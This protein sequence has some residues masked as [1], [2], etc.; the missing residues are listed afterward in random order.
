MLHLRRFKTGDVVHLIGPFWNANIDP[1]RTVDE[2]DQ[3]RKNV[4]ARRAA[5]SVDW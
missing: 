1:Q 4:A 3:V 2:A 5:P